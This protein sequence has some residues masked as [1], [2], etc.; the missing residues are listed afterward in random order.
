MADN[1]QQVQLRQQPQ[2]LTESMKDMYQEK[3]PT[4][5]QVVAV[6][7]LFPIGG[8]LLTLAGFILTITIVGLALTTP[9]F[10]IFSPVLVPAAIVIG[11]A[12]MGF[13][14][15]GAFGITALSSLSWIINYLR[16]PSEKM[17]EHLDYTKRRLQET[18]GQ[19]GQRTKDVG[20]G[21]R[22]QEGGRT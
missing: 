4:T 10:V 8:I 16:G 14:T 13:L 20:Q 15:S 7:T 11:L 21:N 5:S 19:V 9:L 22:G 6:V 17:P 3:G 2:Q 1:P 12:V 18:A